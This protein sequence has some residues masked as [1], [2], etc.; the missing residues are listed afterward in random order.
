MLFFGV[1]FFLYFNELSAGKGFGY[2]YTFTI[3]C[4]YPINNISSLSTVNT[5]KF[6]SCRMGSLVRQCI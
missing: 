3:M 1:C 4:M 2:N 6:L 5:T